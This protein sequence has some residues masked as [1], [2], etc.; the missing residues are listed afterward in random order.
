M[1]IS[2]DSKNPN[3]HNVV[4]YMDDVL[5]NGARL[6]N[7]VEFDTEKGEALCI[8]QPPTDDGTGHVKT[9]IVK[10]KIAIIWRAAAAKSDNGI[11]DPDKMF[12]FFKQ[13]WEERERGRKVNHETS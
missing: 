1:K 3:Y 8:T 12:R 7:V 13:D 11:V 6:S 2:A 4:H 10:G 9:H 5:V